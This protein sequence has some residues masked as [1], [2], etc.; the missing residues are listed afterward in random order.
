MNRKNTPGRD[1]TQAFPLVF[2]RNESLVPGGRSKVS[3]DHR[4]DAQHILG[5]QSVFTN[6]HQVRGE[7]TSL[8]NQ[9]ATPQ[10][11]LQ[12]HKN[13]N[14]IRNFLLSMSIMSLHV[15]THKNKSF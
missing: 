3:S 10:Q 8:L 13:E 12:S 14:G 7:P 11:R 2:H 6:E 9:L 1:V 4:H 15:L 5:A